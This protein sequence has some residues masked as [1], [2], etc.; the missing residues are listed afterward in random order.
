MKKLKLIRII[1]PV[2]VILVLLF[3]GY[4]ITQSESPAYG[5]SSF[6]NGIAP[7]Q[8]RP[9]Q[10]V[11]FPANAEISG[12]LTPTPTFSPIQNGVINNKPPFSP[13]VT[14]LP[15]AHR[16]DLSPNADPIEKAVYMFYRCDGTYDE[17]VVGPGIKIPEDLHLNAGDTIINMLQVGLHSMPPPTI[18]PIIP[19]PIPTAVPVNPN[20][21]TITPFEPYPVP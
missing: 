1:I 20:I 7:T 18:T 2:I 10:C 14:P 13:S 6:A 5:M 15:I 17:F 16:V 12:T 21:P 11:P 9:P 3:V 4:R 8:T 19:T